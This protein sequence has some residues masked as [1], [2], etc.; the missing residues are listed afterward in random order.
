MWSILSSSGEM[1]DLREL[2]GN[3]VNYENIKKIDL[4]ILSKF[5]IFP[6]KMKNRLPSI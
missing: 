1:L 6:S 2:Q 4:S 5:F 3:R